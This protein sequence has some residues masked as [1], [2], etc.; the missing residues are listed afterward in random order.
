MK[1]H[2]GV[3]EALRSPENNQF[4]FDNCAIKKRL[5]YFLEI[6]DKE[7]SVFSALQYIPAVIEMTEDFV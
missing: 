6:F 2:H 3:T 7:R 1:I 4:V 5:K